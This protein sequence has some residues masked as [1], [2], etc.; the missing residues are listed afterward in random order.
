MNSQYRSE[1]HRV[2][3]DIQTSRNNPRS[4]P[5]RPLLSSALELFAHLPSL[6]VSLEPCLHLINK[7]L[8]SLYLIATKMSQILVATQ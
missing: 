3:Q 4:K 7:L 1:N 5:T 6:E 8:E 2:L